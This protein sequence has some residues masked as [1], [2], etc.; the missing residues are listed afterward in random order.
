[1]APDGQILAVN[2]SALSQITLVFTD[3]TGHSVRLK[4]PAKRIVAIAPHLAESLYAAGAGDRLVGTVDYSDYPPAAKTVP[5]V[6]SYDRFDLEEP[7]RGVTRAKFNNGVVTVHHGYF[8]DFIFKG[9]WFEVR[10]IQR[11]YGEHGRF[12]GPYGDADWCFDIE[13]VRGKDTAR[14][15]DWAKRTGTFLKLFGER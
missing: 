3:D 11:D 6:G 5:R 8:T 7:F 1:M 9:P 13:V 10:V 4:A 14:Y 15:L 12:S 2:R